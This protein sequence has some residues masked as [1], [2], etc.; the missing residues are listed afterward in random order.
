MPRKSLKVPNAEELA[1]LA[2]T[3]AAAAPLKQG[4]TS[5]AYIPWS[6][7]HDIRSVLDEAGYPWRD[8]YA[9]LRKIRAKNKTATI[10]K[11]EG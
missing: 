11:S 5:S 9:A 1:F 3:V 7:I 2:L 4:Y 6:T 10:V 8:V